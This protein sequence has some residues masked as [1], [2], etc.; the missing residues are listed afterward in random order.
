MSN[1]YQ[2]LI[3][4]EIKKDR[5][6]FAIQIAFAG[7][8][9]VVCG[10]PLAT[11][12]IAAYIFWAETKSS[13]KEEYIYDNRLLPHCEHKKQKDIEKLARAMKLNHLP[14]L[15][16]H[17]SDGTYGEAHKSGNESL[18]SLSRAVQFS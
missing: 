16:E 1:P 13:K 6:N 12:G 18:V 2:I 11:L 17:P 3:D 14:K 8:A 5:R 7:A 10:M 4:Q 15:Y 9:A